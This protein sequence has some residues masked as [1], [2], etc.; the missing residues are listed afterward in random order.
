MK[1]ISLIMFAGML[2]TSCNSSPAKSS[3][4]KSIY[5]AGEYQKQ[6]DYKLDLSVLSPT[7]APAVAMY[8]FASEINGKYTTTSNPA[9][10]VIPMFQS[11]EYDVI[12]APTD[13]GLNQIVNLGAKYKIAAT[14][15]FG[16]FFLIASGSDEDGVLNKG[17]SV[18]IFQENGIP[19]KT[20]NYLYNDLELNVTAVG[21]ASDTK[22]IIENN[23]VFDNKKYDYVLS[24][25]PVV[26]ATNST[27]FLDIQSEFAR[28]SGGKKMTQAS[29]F[30]KNGVSKAKADKFLFALKDAINDGVANPDLIKTAIESIG[31]AQEQSSAFG[32]P[33]AIAK[34]AT[35]AGNRLNLGF[36]FASDIKED[37]RTFVNIVNTDVKL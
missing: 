7:G 29:V 19:G 34:K 36:E 33:G 22:S 4:D 14:V 17:D 37:I 15:T 2:L 11:G 35:A 18:I 10:G 8:Q 25:E 3:L 20:F 5:H 13:S 12:I 9:V 24:A 21:A 16:N 30:I 28:V 26:S 32:V 23:F 6:V 31:S 27:V 1:K